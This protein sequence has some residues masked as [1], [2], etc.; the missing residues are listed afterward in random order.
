MRVILYIVNNSVNFIGHPVQINISVY[1]VASLLLPS[2]S[3]LRSRVDFHVVCVQ[4]FSLQ[5]SIVLQH[6]QQALVRFIIHPANLD[7]FSH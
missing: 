1:S 3:A 6:L 5:F 2:S 7:Q 4:C